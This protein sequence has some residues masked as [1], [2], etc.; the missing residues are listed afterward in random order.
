MTRKVRTRNNTVDVNNTLW[1]ML[2]LLFLILLY[3]MSFVVGSGAS[4][5]GA[6]PPTC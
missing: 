5:G 6:P 2:P 4:C 1:K 3:V